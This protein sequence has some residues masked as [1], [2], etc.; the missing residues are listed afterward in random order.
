MC[1]PGSLPNH[2]GGVH[3]VARGSSFSDI[4]TKPSGIA[5]GASAGDV[6][7]SAEH[8]L[9]NANTNEPT[10]QRCWVALVFLAHRTNV[11]GGKRIE[12]RHGDAGNIDIDVS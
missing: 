12:L 9:A 10:R 2:F 11:K 8:A 7:G 6:A 3:F 1:C 5:D 4:K